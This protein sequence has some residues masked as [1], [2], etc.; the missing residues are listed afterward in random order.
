MKTA[1]QRKNRV[2]IEASELME[3]GWDIAPV[4]RVPPLFLFES[5]SKILRFGGG[6]PDMKKGEC[7][8]GIVER[9]DYPGKGRVVLPEG[10][11]AVKLVLP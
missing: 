11:A 9:V 8:E 3:Q 6:W 7:R 1:P 10:A 2:Y 4:A 5:E